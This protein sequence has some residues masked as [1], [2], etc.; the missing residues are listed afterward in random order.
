[1][2]RTV[3]STLVAVGLTTILLTGSSFAQS[4][5][6]SPKSAAKGAPAAI[7]QAEAATGPRT[8]INPKDG[9][10]YVWIQPGSYIIGCS[11]NDND[12][13]RD[14]KRN[15]KITL[16]RGFWIGETETTQA[17]YKKIMPKNPSRFQG[18]NLPVEFITQEDAQK[19][20]VA[21]GARLP[22]EA[23][24]EWAARGGTPGPRY[25]NLDDIAWYFNNS[26]HHTHPV[27]LKQPNAY[28]LKDML[29]NVAEWTNTVYQTY[30]S[31]EGINPVGPEDG[32][33]RSLRGGGW[34]DKAPIVRASYRSRIEP[35]EF[36]FNIG[37]R[38]A[39]N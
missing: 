7:K 23:E 39:M 10:K 17:A 28:G 38:C 9:L 37:F 4:T 25:G 32:E 22:T 20:C 16:T 6:G 27:G 34:F 19:Y 36:D 2:N 13:Y 5:K 18:N 11:P 21:V 30:L 26:D 14:E 31:W 29:G 8:K 3:T 24:W 12:C 33:Y 1:M 15:M 35:D